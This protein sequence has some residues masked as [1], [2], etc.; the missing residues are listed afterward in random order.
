MPCIRGGGGCQGGL[1][2]PDHPPVL[3]G[4]AWAAWHAA[5]LPIVVL[6]RQP[7]CCCLATCCCMFTPAAQ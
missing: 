5:G 3:L 6:A 2:A 1:H 4:L 7:A